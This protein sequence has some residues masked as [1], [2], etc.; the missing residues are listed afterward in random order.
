MNNL[1]PPEKRPDLRSSEERIGLQ[2]PFS[3]EYHK[4]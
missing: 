3:L 4:Q 2:N 1:S